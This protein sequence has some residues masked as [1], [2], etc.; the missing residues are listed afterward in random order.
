[1]DSLRTENPRAFRSGSVNKPPFAFQV[2]DP[3]EDSSE[4]VIVF[5]WTEGQAR[6]RGASFLWC[7]FDE[8]HTV[9]V[10][11]LPDYDQYHA[12]GYVPPVQLIHDG[13]NL[14]C[15]C[16]DV[17]VDLDAEDEETGEPL[18]FCEVGN[19][20][21]CSDSCRDS[22]EEYRVRSRI[23][24]SQAKA[25]LM[26]RYPGISRLSTWL[27]D[28]EVGASFSF[29]G[30]RHRATWTSKM[31]NHTTICAVDL[32]AWEAAFGKIKEAVEV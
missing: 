32:P 25:C 3:D 16:C 30:G 18:D 27:N 7:D 14:P 29:P 15:D 1:M 12:L 26:S 8:L 13:W 6:S 21:Y 20:L 31:P 2:S 10:K 23:R 17:M 28:E 9:P 19:R 24:R 5:A 4:A 22:H 11:R